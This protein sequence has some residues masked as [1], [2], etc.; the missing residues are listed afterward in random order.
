M[1][2]FLVPVDK[3]ATD[4]KAFERIAGS[5]AYVGYLSIVQ[6]SS[7]LAKPPAKMEQGTFAFVEANKAVN[8]GEKVNVVL[9][10]WRPTA[11]IVDKRGSSTV[12][13]SYHD[14]DQDQFKAI[15]AAAEGKQDP[16]YVNYVGPEYLLWLDD[17]EKFA[18]FYCNSI[19]LRRA[20]REALQGC[21]SNQ[22]QIKLVEFATR[23]IEN[24]NYKWYG[25][26]AE[27]LANQDPNNSPDSDLMDR[28]FNTF[29]NAKGGTDS[30]EVKVETAETDDNR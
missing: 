15:S 4:V 11:R 27:V 3:T 26:D 10:A 23:F 6:S 20:A 22:G 18:T 5:G 9:V 8:L 29:V 2:G 28:V 19:T 24:K 1:S 17:Q 30:E 7:D 25:L 14:Q 21:M 13:T 16:N 12:I